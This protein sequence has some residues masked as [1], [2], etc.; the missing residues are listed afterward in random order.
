MQ[1]NTAQVA[2]ALILPSPDADVI[3]GG[4]QKVSAPSVYHA[5][6][7]TSGVDQQRQIYL[8]QA[9][10]LDRGRP[11]PQRDEVMYSRVCAIE[12]LAE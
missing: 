11:V 8:Q 4:S 10:S 1:T 2:A 3:L 12:R 9:A 5:D 6:R 7:H